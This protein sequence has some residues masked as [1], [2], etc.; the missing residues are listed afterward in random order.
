MRPELGREPT[1]A[2][3]EAAL[4]AIVDAGKATGTPT[5]MHTMSV[6]A[7]EQRLKQGMRFWPWGAISR[8]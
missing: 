1:D 2:E 3:F 8:C 7:A 5:G 4:Q 6:A